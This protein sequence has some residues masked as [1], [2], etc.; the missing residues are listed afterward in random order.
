MTKISNITKKVLT[1]EEAAMYLGIT[2]NYLY[3]LV[4]R[5]AIS[6]YKPN[7]KMLYFDKSDLN[8]FMRRNKVEAKNNEA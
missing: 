4:H 8:K 6:Y 7:G 5:K 1:L 3:Q 2:K